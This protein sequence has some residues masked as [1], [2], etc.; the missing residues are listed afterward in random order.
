[1][2]AILRTTHNYFQLF[3]GLMLL[4]TIGLII[5]NPGLVILG[6]NDRYVLIVLI[7]GY[8][9]FE[10]AWLY[11]DFRKHRKPLLEVDPDVQYSMVHHFK[12]VTLPILQYRWSSMFPKKK[13]SAVK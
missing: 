13:Q 10:F 5:G 12:Q 9:L 6:L 4:I 2:N 8:L 11:I 7:V 1:M 3:F